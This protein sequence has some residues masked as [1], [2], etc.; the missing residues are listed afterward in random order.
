MGWRS[1]KGPLQRTSKGVRVTMSKPERELLG[2]LLD[3]LR[4]MLLAGADQPN[5]RRLFPP[6]YHQ[7]ID[8]GAETE[9][10]RLMGDELVAARLDA[11]DT[12]TR[13]IDDDALLDEAGA[14]AFLRA[15][16]QLRLVLGTALDLS[17]DDEPALVA[18]DHPLAGE[19]H[20]YHYLSWLLEHAIDCLS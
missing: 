13:A 12:V 5:L 2:R 16:N 20:L 11:I 7:A 18:D 14:M 15:V 8:A 6:A 9:Y 10:Q 1:P 19:M 4:T 17:E 3:Q